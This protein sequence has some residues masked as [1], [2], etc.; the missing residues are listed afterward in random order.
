MPSAERHN[1]DL[2]KKI[3]FFFFYIEPHR[4]LF[5][6]ISLEIQYPEALTSFTSV[7]RIYQRTAQGSTLQILAF[8]SEIKLNV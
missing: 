8:M 2:R 4:S 5:Q 3:F 1:E 7:K 6:D